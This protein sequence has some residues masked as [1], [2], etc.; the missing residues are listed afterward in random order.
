MTRVSRRVNAGDVSDNISWLV[1]ANMWRF[2]AC[3]PI[4]KEARPMMMMHGLSFAGGRRGDF[5]D[6]DERVLEYNSV[7]AGRCGDGVI[8][9]RKIRRILRKAQSLP[10]A[11]GDQEG[12]HHGNCYPDA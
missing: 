4:Q 3:I 1:V 11:H 6:A 12:T 9:L 7:T 10:S 2:P 5:Q 8:A